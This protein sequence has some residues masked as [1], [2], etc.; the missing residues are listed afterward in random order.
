MSW[1]KR[2]KKQLSRFSMPW[3]AS[4]SPRPS[5]VS[6]RM[7]WGSSVMPTPSSS[8]LRRALV[9][10][11]GDAALVQGEREGEPADAAADDHDVHGFR[12]RSGVGGV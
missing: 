3:A 11:A 5:A 8:H 2:L 4:A 7:P 9:D 1:P 10:A 12:G 6:S